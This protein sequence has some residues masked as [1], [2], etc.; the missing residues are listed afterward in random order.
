M[1]TKRAEAYPWALADC[2]AYACA[3]DVGWS[4]VRRKLD[5]AACAKCSHRIGEASH[6]GPR[7]RK[8]SRPS[9]PN[10]AIVEFSTLLLT[11]KGLARWERLL[12]EVVACEACS[13]SLCAVPRLVDLLLASF[14]RHLY[15]EDAPVHVIRHVVTALQ[16]HHLHLKRQTIS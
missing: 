13:A 1:L 3:L 5:V 7:K 10:E 9:F 12:K 16:R 4:D 2:L 6:P 11:E 15:Y 8:L 14:V